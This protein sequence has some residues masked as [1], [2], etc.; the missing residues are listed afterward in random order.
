[1]IPVDVCMSVCLYVC[2]TLSEFC[3]WKGQHCLCVGRTAL[4]MC[5]FDR[6]NHSCCVQL[7]SE[8]KQFAHTKQG[9]YH[10]QRA[11]AIGCCWTS[12]A[13]HTHIHRHV[14]SIAAAAGPPVQYTHKHTRTQ[15]DS[16]V[17]H[18]HTHTQARAIHCCCRRPSCAVHIRT[19]TYTHA[20][21]H[22][23][24]RKESTITH[25][26]H[27]CHMLPSNLL[28]QYKHTHTMVICCS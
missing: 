13:V 8:G 19:L 16:P 2:V 5:A 28:L 15:A 4:S 17:Q 14:Q 26:L 25:I 10:N 11:L 21:T 3:R 9:E 20:H 23:Q 24:A 1:M 12:C 27:T 6:A 7:K 18:T 22:T